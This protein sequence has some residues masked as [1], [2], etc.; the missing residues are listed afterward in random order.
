MAPSVWPL[1]PTL[2]RGEG[3]IL[4]DLDTRAPGLD[5]GPWPQPPRTAM[6]LPVGAAGQGRAPVAV[7]VAGVSRQIPLDNAYRQFF[8]LLADQVRTLLAAAYARRDAQDKLAALTELARAKDEF[9]ANVSH[10]FRD[11]LT[12]MLLPLEELTGLPG[13]HGEPA[14]MAYR[15]ALR[16]LRL[17]NSLLATPNSNKAAPS[18]SLRRSPTSR[19]SPRTWSAC[20]VPPWTARVSNCGWTA[21]PWT[22]P[23]SWIRRCGKQSC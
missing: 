4:D 1:R 9:F 15:N 23:S 2:D 5:A 16:L 19:L 22:G 21:R 6:V 7:L 13:Q 14:R 8:D 10:E 18:P 3:Q 17:V 11:P 12:L 20:C